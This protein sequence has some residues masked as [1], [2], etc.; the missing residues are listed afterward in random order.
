MVKAILDNSSN[1]LITSHL[2]P[3]GDAIGSMIAMGKALEKKGKNI[4]LYNES[5]IPKIFSFLPGIEKINRSVPDYSKFDTAV[6]LDCSETGRTG[7][8]K[9]ILKSIP[10]I[11]NID[12]HRTNSNFGTFR[13]IEPKA[14]ATAEIVYRIIKDLGV[15]ICSEIAYS[16][17]T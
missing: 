9:K 14:S 4:Y 2:H 17:Y 6:I 11:I 15:E 13:I 12:H 1:I 3:D 16:I 10:E 8:C 5:C 7:K